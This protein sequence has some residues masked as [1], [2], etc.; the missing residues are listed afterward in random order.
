MKVTSA[1][2][3]MS[4]QEVRKINLELK[5]TIENINEENPFL[6]TSYLQN[7]TILISDYVFKLSYGLYAKKSRKRVDDKLEKDKL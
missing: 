7:N 3:G 2:Q 5:H 6:L 4:I 1:I